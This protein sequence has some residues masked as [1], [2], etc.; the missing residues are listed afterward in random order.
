MTHDKACVNER[1][2]KKMNESYEATEIK[3]TETHSRPIMYFSGVAFIFKEPIFSGYVNKCQ[4]PPIL[5][6]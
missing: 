2:K 6:N 4:I 3:S 1:M 5:A